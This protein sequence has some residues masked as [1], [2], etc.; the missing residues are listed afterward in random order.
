MDE[1]LHLE[2]R[3]RF[4]PDGSDLRRLQLRQIDMLKYL[5]NICRKNDIKYWLA[6]GNLLGYVRHFGEF[7]PWDDDIDIEIE[8]NDYKRLIAI[9][10]KEQHPDFEVQHGSNDRYFEV[11]FAKLRDKHSF[12]PEAETD[13]YRL[14]GC[15]IDIFPMR[16]GFKSVIKFTT[17]LRRRYFGI[18]ARR[19]KFMPL[20]KMLTIVGK[21]L[22]I[23]GFFPLINTIVRPFSRK[24]IV[25]HSPAA[26]A[27]DYNPRR[28]ANLYPLQRIVFEGIEVNAPANPDGFLRDMYGDYMTVPDPDKLH[29]HFDREKI[30]WK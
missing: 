19:V 8:Y 25:Y 3:Q 28:I 11:H 22:L 29:Y 2:L 14:K 5:D 4:N 1:S 7:I 13:L 6:A 21:G 15:Y 9:L 24:D 26:V 20:R 23:Q 12:I 10:K 16:R 27:V 30:I 17:N 18:L